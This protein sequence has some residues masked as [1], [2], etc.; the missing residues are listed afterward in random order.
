MKI[1]TASHDKN[2]LGSLFRKKRFSH[3]KDLIE[4][5]VKMKE[6]K[7]P[8][9]VLDIGGLESYW[10]NME[11][12]WIKNLD[13]TI[14]NLELPTQPKEYKHLA[15]DATNLVGFQ[16]KHFDLVFSN[17]VIEH[18]FN[19]DNQKKMAKEIIRVGKFYYVQTPNKFFFIEPHY[20]LPFFQFLPKNFQF[21]IL[22]KL[23][24]SRL[25]RWSHKAA[26]DYVDEIRLLSPGEMKKLFEHSK[27]Y[28]EKFLGL[29]KSTIMHNL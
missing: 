13:I 23:P 25:K 27:I 7:F 24:L 15:G 9:R 19:F 17:S 22:T 20:L 6:L 21:F 5:K 28:F 1:F 29:R 26:R 16:D 11:D 4:K 14:L 3:F 10:K 18:L 8:I 12:D 2:S